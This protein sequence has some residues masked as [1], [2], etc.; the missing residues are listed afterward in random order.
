MK[1]MHILFI[2]FLL[3]FIE[4]KAQTPL[5]TDDFQGKLTNATNA[6]LLDVRTPQEYKEGHLSNSLNIDYK[7][8]D[9]RK[10]IRSLDKTKPV[11]VYCLAGSRSA[12]AAEILHEAGFSEIYDM[13]GGYLKW[14]SS[15]KLIDAPVNSSAPTGMTATEFKKISDAKGLVLVDFYAPWCEPCIKMLPTVHKL[16]SEYKGKARIETIQYDNNKALARNLSIEEIPTFLLYKDGK[17]L[18]RKKGFMEEHEFR[19]LIDSNL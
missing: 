15:G 19:K 9:F 12:A 5:S 10:K 1:L 17:L 7:S 4:I 2:A 13:K 18:I 3:L 16:A 14:T 8:S 6:Q 11:F